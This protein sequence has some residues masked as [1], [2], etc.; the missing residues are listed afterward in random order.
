MLGYKRCEYL[1][2]GVLRQCLRS[3]EYQRLKSHWNNFKYDPT[4]RW[5]SGNLWRLFERFTGDRRP[6]RA[7]HRGGQRGDPFVTVD[8]RRGQRRLPERRVR[9]DPECPPDRFQPVRARLGE[10]HGHPERLNFTC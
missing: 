10:H 1:G 8:V 5:R 2:D 6:V 9:R 3:F 4:G 7:R